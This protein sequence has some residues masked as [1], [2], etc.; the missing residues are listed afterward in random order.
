MLMR[1]SIALIAL[2]VYAAAAPLPPEIA[3]CKVYKIWQFSNSS[4]GWRP[5]NNVG[6]FS[7]SNGVLS[8]TN[9][10]P[11]PWIINTDLGGPDTSRY[12]R[13]GIKMRSS[14]GGS[15]QVYFAT[16]KSKMGESGSVTTP[17]KADGKFHFYE[18]DLSQ[19]KSWTG[20]LEVLRIDPVNGGSEVGAKV[21]IDWIALYQPPARLVFGFPSIEKSHYSRARWVILPITNSGG[22]ASPNLLVRAN[23]GVERV[24]PLKPGETTSVR[25][26]TG[27]WV[28]AK[29]EPVAVVRDDAE[30]GTRIAIEVRTPEKT[31]YTADLMPGP[32]GANTFDLPD[33]S[34]FSFDETT[35]PD[36]RP[37]I[38]AAGAY[39]EPYVGGPTAGLSPLATLIYRDGGGVLHYDE[40]IPDAGSLSI[41]GSTATLHGRH[42]L[43]RGTAMIDWTFVSRARVAKGAK[44]PRYAR[45]E[46]TCSL[47][48]DAPVDV[49]RFEGPR[50]RLDQPPSSAPMDYGPARPF[51]EDYTHA[52]FP[53][54]QY[55]E[56]DEA[57]SAIGFI[58]PKLADEHI[59][60]PYKITIPVMAIETTSGVI[61]MSWNPLQEWAP[62]H[63]LPCAQFDA[64]NGIMSLFAP[65]IPEYVEEN[66]DYA[67]TAYTLE[68]GQKMT[69][70]MTFFSQD[71]KKI[72]D[73]IP[74]YFA[75]HGLPK[76]PAIV[77]GVESA[78]DTCFKAYAGTLYSK[79]ANGW[80]SHFGLH[81]PYT[82][83]STYAALILGESIRE[84][85]PELAKKC[86]IDPNAQLTQYI[87]TTLDWFTD[88]A[89][90]GAEAAIAKQSPDGGF[91]YTVTED[92]SKR[93]QEFKEMSGVDT[94]NLGKVGSTNSG[95][96][97]R[98][99]G[100]ILDCAV[101][102]GDKKCVDAGLLGLA[103][104]DSFTVPRGAQTW[105][106]HAHA[107]DVY[108]AALAINCNLAG[109]HLTRD[110][111]Y[112]DY[113]RFWAQTGLPFV[114]SWVVPISSVPDIVLHFDDSGEGK[115]P[116]LARPDVF[117][118]DIHRHINP[119][120]TI[121]VFGS[122]FYFVNWFG[123]PVQWCGL[124]WANSV[125]AYT[126]LRPDPVLQAVADSVFASGTQ[127]QF[128]KGFVA[129]TYP[130]SWN[131][132]SNSVNTA[133]IGP[134]SI[135]SYAYTL[136]G[137]KT[138]SAVSTAS[139]RLGSDVVRLNTFASIQRI[140][141]SPNGLTATL[142]FYPNQD[143]YACFVPVDSPADVKVDGKSLTAAADLKA[144]VSGFYYNSERRALHVKYRVPSR[145]AELSVSWAR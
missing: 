105:E 109:Y 3:D 24:P 21:D 57:Y 63:K 69:L 52:L 76:A 78:I 77:G 66:H 16:D 112:L 25:V 120:A 72:T 64:R 88:A 140:T 55:L 86:G 79:Q 47:T 10:G 144:S 19:L 104:L 7:I 124:A 48:A 102:T 30:S 135:L 34:G 82:P 85:K 23:K 4:E 143:V 136:I 14:V 17:A 145:T 95:L 137:E 129:G 127:Q 12:S 50:M 121:A 106:V 68:P 99:L 73:V 133:F 62:G 43:A 142:K 96:I 117:Y 45:D 18:I 90:A 75:A 97:A 58:G 107:P 59:P 91:P 38:R 40:L 101:H 118:S 5:D 11:D 113:A 61:G 87:G 94:D 125:R 139:F 81:L 131:L 1:M 119:G 71:G 37:Y 28:F 114:Y 42:E 33:G 22:E 134:D 56:K 103:K 130:D 44:I 126:K 41:K 110:E 39:I 29:D 132:Q 115:N 74:D 141:N 9:T 49:L 80:K 32:G 65:S 108:A 93:I 8:F 53:G 51:L 84:S 36:G 15:N 60:H 26:L 54:L 46:I 92:I 116:V 138:P 20:K 70:K 122:S 27:H 67:T 100:A 123:T 83:N 31:Y 35:G 128:D 2:S 111:Q 89:R 13:V 98:E 6:P